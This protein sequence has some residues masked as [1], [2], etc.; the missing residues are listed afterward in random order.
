MAPVRLA[1]KY[2]TS[3]RDIC[4]TQVS[5]SLSNMVGKQLRRVRWNSA[6][7]RC[8]NRSATCT[9]PQEV[10]VTTAYCACT[11]PRSTRHNCQG[12]RDTYVIVGSSTFSEEFAS[13]VVGVSQSP[14]HVLLSDRR[15]QAVILSVPATAHDFRGPQGLP[16]TVV[17]LVDVVMY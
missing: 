14:A 8:N 15:A 10:Q 5:S 3:H 17:E 9:H 12:Q 1:N 2:V 4:Q 16:A 13:N 11:C 6:R 7:R